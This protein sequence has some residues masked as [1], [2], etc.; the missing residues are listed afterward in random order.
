VCGA[1]I[2]TRMPPR[3]WIPRYHYR[4]RILGLIDVSA[5]PGAVGFQ[6]LACVQLHF[7][8]S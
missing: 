1:H 6:Y 4:A 8:L 2:C 3:G 5:A 7:S